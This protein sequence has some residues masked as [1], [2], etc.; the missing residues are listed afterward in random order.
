M[1][2]GWCNM[3]G[4]SHGSTAREPLAIVARSANNEC[5]FAGVTIPKTVAHHAWRDFEDGR[6]RARAATADSASQES[7][8]TLE[9][10][11]DLVQK[12]EEAF[13]LELLEVAKARVQMRVAP[14]TWEAFR[15]V[16]LEGRPVA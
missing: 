12:L 7:I 1:L 10:R 8:L 11:E 9:A 4:I 14:H 2:S 13:D 6:R 15:L 16:A 3:T 5:F